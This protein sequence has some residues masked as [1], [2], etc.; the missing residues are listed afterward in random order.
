MSRRPRKERCNTAAVIIILQQRIEPSSQTNVRSSS[1]GRSEPID[2]FFLQI[3]DRT[4][5]SGR[6]GDHNK[7]KQLL[8]DVHF[9]VV[10]LPLTI[11]RQKCFVPINPSAVDFCTIR[12]NRRVF[13]ALYSTPL[14]C[15]ST[16]GSR[17]LGCTL[18]AK[19]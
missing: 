17:E 10:I 16:R 6:T 4:H 8:C 14:G 9:D 3:R 5:R 12:G 18:G 15:P 19:K 2:R 7:Q 1:A 13:K 11:E